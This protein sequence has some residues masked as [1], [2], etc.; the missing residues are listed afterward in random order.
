MQLVLLDH[1]LYREL[2]RHFTLIY[3]RLW[4]GLVLG[5][6]DERR[7]REWELNLVSLYRQGLVEKL[8]LSL[9]THIAE[10]ASRKGRPAEDISLYTV[11]DCSSSVGGIV[12]SP[13]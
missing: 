1:G 10:D 11:F 6:A 9:A 4:R 12:N 5:D 3:S 7:V 8:K 2:P 13:G